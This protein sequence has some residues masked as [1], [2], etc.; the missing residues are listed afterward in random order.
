METKLTSEQYFD[1]FYRHYPRKT[2]KLAA[3]KAWAKVIKLPNVTPEDIIAGAQSYA[4]LCQKNAKEAEFIPHPASWLNAG[5]WADEEAP[6]AKAKEGNKD[7]KKITDENVQAVRWAVWETI[8]ALP[9]ARQ[10]VAEG[11]AWNLKCAVLDG[12]IKSRD[13]IN[14]KR[15]LQEHTFSEANETRVRMGQ[16]LFTLC[17]KRARLDEFMQEKYLNGRLNLKNSEAKTADEIQKVQKVTIF[18]E[19]E[20]EKET[21][22]EAQK[23]E[24]GSAQ[25]EGDFWD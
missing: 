13:Q 12:S 8:R 5:R 24:N 17:G 15:F 1:E 7:K 10:A 20:D 25:E 6:K 21:F 2:A 18:T 9:V 11:W 3:Q 23:E 19:K 4:A 22:A 14:E 16:P